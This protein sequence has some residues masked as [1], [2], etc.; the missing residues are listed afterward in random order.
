MWVIN[1]QC[2]EQIILNICLEASMAADLNK[3]S[4]RLTAASGVANTLSFESF[5]NTYN[6]D[7]Q[8]LEHW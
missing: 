1:S 8:S 4:A 7:S 2:T 3:T 6:G 5:Q